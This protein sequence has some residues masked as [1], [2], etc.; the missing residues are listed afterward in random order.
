MIPYIVITVLGVGASVLMMGGDEPPTPP[1]AP[2]SVVT[3]P[4]FQPLSDAMF[5]VG[6]CSVAC[7]M[8]WG[9]CIVYTARLKRKASN[10]YHH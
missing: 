3:Q 8:I 1:P 6:G 10:E 7:S 9:A 4:S 5:W 2:V